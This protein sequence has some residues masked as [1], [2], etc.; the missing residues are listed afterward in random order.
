MNDELQRVTDELERWLREDVLP[1][2]ADSGTDLV[3]G[4]FFE[5]IAEDGAP[6][7][8]PRRSRV[9]ARQIYVFATAMR[10]GWIESAS[11]RVDHGLTFL[12]DRIQLPSGMFAT[13][14]EVAG[15]PV[16]AEFALYEHAFVLFALAAA[17]RAK[18]ERKDLPREASL[19]LQRMRNG[20]AH[21]MGGFNESQ[22]PIAPLQSN[23]HMHLFEAMLE[24]TLADQGDLGTQ[25]GKLADEI[26][27]LCLAKMIN[28]ATGALHEYFDLDW[29]RREDHAGSVIEPGH[30]FEWA[31]LLLRWG[32]WR[33][34]P[35]AIEAARRL[36]EIGENDGVDTRRGIAINE[37]NADLSVRSRDAKLWPQ[38]ER[39]KA[40]CAMAVQA[41]GNESMLA[42]SKANVT[43]AAMG[44]LEY[45]VGAQPGRWLEVCQ[46]DGTFSREPTR[47]SSLYHIVCAFDTLK[48]A[49][50]QLS[51]TKRESV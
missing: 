47:A 6:T 8:E 44:L 25:C 39:I 9:V 33:A 11:E 4:G 19:L 50:D 23:P 32:Q 15:T 43:S 14:V 10:H 3:D 30:Q 31:W 28:P 21:P 27:E 20:W 16:N 34:R 24:W 36:A 46:A 26:A 1:F 13:S 2:W 29:Q 35:D 7:A 38:T 22:P 12:F 17:Y 5:R 41:S 42:R 51:G 37:L 48:T 45:S 18:P 40:W 49:V